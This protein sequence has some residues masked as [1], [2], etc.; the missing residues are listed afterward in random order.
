MHGFQKVGRVRTRAVAAPMVVMNQLKPK[1]KALLANIKPCARNKYYSDTFLEQLLCIIK[2][3][4]VQT[5]VPSKD[6]T[7]FNLTML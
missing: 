6:H 4:Y 3:V 2:I 1:Y 5:T 7:H